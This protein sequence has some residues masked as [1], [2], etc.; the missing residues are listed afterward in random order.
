ML[1]QPPGSLPLE[2]ALPASWRQ[3]S[4]PFS[5]LDRGGLGA[6]A[7]KWHVTP[8]AA[9]PPSNPCF[10]GSAQVALIVSLAQFTAG[11]NPTTGAAAPGN[12]LLTAA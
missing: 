1:R 3:E 9:C 2:Q 5:Q 6:Q 10:S 8:T 7:V 11:R 4:L 12:R